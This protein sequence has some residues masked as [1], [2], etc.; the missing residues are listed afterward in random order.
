LLKLF[1]RDFYSEK[2]VIATLRVRNSLMLAHYVL[3]TGAL[4]VIGFCV[5]V[6]VQAAWYQA[7]AQAELS[8]PSALPGAGSDGSQSSGAQAN[9]LKE[10][11]PVGTL[12]IPRAHISALIAEGDSP[13]VLRVAI[14]HVPGTALP[15]QRGNIGLVAHRDTFFRRLGEVQTGDLIRIKGPHGSYSYRVTFTDIVSPRETWVLQPATGRTLTL[16]TC[17][18]FHY[19]GAAPKRFVVRAR[20]VDGVEN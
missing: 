12:E 2:T 8:S 4:V 9:L 1:A 14:G 3:L 10:M 11:T 6:A 15:A 17:Y 19:I 20:A 7:A 5:W 16:V 18:P 13:Q